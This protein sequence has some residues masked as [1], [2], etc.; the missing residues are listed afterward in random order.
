MIFKNSDPTDIKNYRPISLL[1]VDYKIISKVYANRFTCVLS[2]LLG[3]MQ[4]AVKGRN[5]ANGLVLLRDVIDFAQKNNHE[6]YVLSL[7][8]SKAFDCVN[9]C[10]LRKVLKQ[11]GFLRT[12]C[13]HIFTLLQN[14][15]TAV[16]VNEFISD[17]FPGEK[18]CKT[19]GPT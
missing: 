10:F 9:R 19:R 2:D 18:R 3:S 12:F 15:E 11:S 8:F 6:T 5:V 7:D 13:D 16:I 1:N 17:F 14:S 4:Y